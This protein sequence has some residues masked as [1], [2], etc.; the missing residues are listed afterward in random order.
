MVQKFSLPHCINWVARCINMWSSSTS[1]MD[2]P[3]KNK[4]HVDFSENWIT[5][6]KTNMDTQNGHILK[7]STF[8]KPS[9]GYSVSFRGCRAKN[10]RKTSTNLREPQHTLGAYPRHP[11]TPKWKKF[12]TI[13]CWLGVWGMLQGSVGKFLEQ[14]F[15]RWGSEPALQT[16]MVFSFL[17][18]WLES[19]EVW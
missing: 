11:Q 9:L 8:S 16:P 10:V 5:P 18:G 13:N 17:F 19:Y 14:T 7:K 3:Q 15:T 12:R 6:Q 1:K 4:K 2:T